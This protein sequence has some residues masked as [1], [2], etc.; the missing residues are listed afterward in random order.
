[1][2]LERNSLISHATPAGVVYFHWIWMM[3][4]ICH[5]IRDEEMF[6]RGAGP[7]QPRIVTR[8]RPLRAA[9]ECWRFNDGLNV[10]LWFVA[11]ILPRGYHPGL[12]SYQPFG[13]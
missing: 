11:C 13:L 9:Q 5:P 7:Y 2:L 3:L 1:M 10:R 8:N 12:Q 4:T 6:H